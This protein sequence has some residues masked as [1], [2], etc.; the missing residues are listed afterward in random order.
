VGQFVLLGLRAETEFVD[1]V[2]DLTQV[3]AVGDLV[4]NLCEDLPDLVFD[5]VEPLAFCL[6]PLR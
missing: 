1:V 4:F 2:D 6:K 3:I 5:G